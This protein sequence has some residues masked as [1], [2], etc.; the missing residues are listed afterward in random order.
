MTSTKRKEGLGLS[1]SLIGQNGRMNRIISHMATRSGQHCLVSNLVASRN[2]GGP[3][4]LRFR[5]RTFL[6]DESLAETTNCVVD[7]SIPRATFFYLKLVLQSEVGLVV[8]TT[9]F[10]Q[11]EQTFLADLPRLTKTIVSPNTSLGV[12]RFFD[13]VSVASHL[14]GD[15]YDA[16]ILETHHREKEDSPSGTALSIG[17]TIANNR[18]TSFSRN[19]VLS[20]CQVRRQRRR[21]EIGFSSVRGGE[22]V[23]EHRVM[24]ISDNET[25]VLSHSSANRFHYAEGALLAADRISWENHTFRSMRDIG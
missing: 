9:G 16:E 22:V 23:G 10:L 18:F 1:I 19:V 20:R 14:L 6:S 3:Q 7:F 24:F 5:V 12:N 21:A 4:F 2:I 11:Q 17:R 8:S 25:L 15:E 13:I